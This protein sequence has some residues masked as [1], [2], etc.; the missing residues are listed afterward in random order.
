MSRGNQ[1][2]NIFRDG[3]DRLGGCFH[4]GRSLPENRLAGACLFPDAQSLTLG[5]RNTFGQPGD[6]NEPDGGEAEGGNAG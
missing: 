5:H 1:R 6:W 4:A 3:A 2:Q